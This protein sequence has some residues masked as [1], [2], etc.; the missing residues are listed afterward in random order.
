MAVKGLLKNARRIGRP[1]SLLPTGRPLIRPDKKHVG[2]FTLLVNI[3]KNRYADPNLPF[4][5]LY[6]I[7]VVC[8][9][10]S[11][12]EEGKVLVGLG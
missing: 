1:C 2:I 9:P 10:K 5:P 7:L 8:C 4:T 3:M 11:Q 12:Y 6:Y